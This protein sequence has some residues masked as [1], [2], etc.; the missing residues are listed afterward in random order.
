MLG[1][2]HDEDVEVHGIPEARIDK[3][4]SDFSREPINPQVGP[5]RE[6]LS[7]EDKKT[8]LEGLV[9]KAPPDIQQ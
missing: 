3:V 5:A 7:E 1:F 2:F 9:I 4:F 6:Q 8:L